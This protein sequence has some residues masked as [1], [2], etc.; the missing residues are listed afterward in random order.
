M[1]PPRWSAKLA[2]VIA[3]AVAGFLST[4]FVAN[5]GR[6]STAT[7][8][9]TTAAP[10]APVVTTGVAPTTGAWAPITVTRPK[11]PII[12][13]GIPVDVDPSTSRTDFS[14]TLVSLGANR[15][16][17]TV[18]NTS[19]LGAINTFQ[20]Y[21]PVGVK[22]VK[23]MGSTRGRCT[24]T[25]LTGFGGNQFPTL[26]LYPNIFCDRV[27]LAPATCTCRG[28]G[29]SVTISFQTSKPIAVNE[30]ELRL[31]AATV[32]FD[33]I[34]TYVGAPR[35]RHIKR[36][37]TAAK[38]AGGLTAGE[39]KG[40]QTALDSLQDSNIS[41][42]LVTIS[43]RWVQSVP[44]TCR[45]ALESR[46]PETYR[47]YLFWVPWLAAEPYVWLTMNVTGDPGTS[48][49]RLG[50]SQPVLP[51]G[52]LQ[53]NGRTV[54]RLTVDTTLLSRYGEEQAKK[55]RQLMRA[56]SG[57]VF[58]KPGASCQV[59]KNGSLRLVAK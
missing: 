15:Y 32:V 48:T 30:G 4:L 1:R 42:Q 22:I 6:G 56:H 53:R 14:T 26:V 20:W 54:N 46:S 12:A 41:L 13:G 52:R 19:T 3:C 49:F 27:A 58:T 36:I 45:V 44:A 38:P 34:P 37:V 39:R 8:Q 16:R 25:G 47:V 31:R 50:A 11:I 18:F 2:L 35:T 51:G 21:P 24:Q 5:D 7:G 23:V 59:L 28:D 9:T 33:R 10:P 17:M 43:T 57:G 29:G 40:A 55:G